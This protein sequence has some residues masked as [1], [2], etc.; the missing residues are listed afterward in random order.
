MPQD[1]SESDAFDI[2]QEEDISFQVN[3][4][5][6]IKSQSPNKMQEVIKDA[7][8]SKVIDASEF[9]VKFNL[10]VFV[11]VWIYHLLFFY[12]GFVALAFIIPI[13]SLALAINMGFWF[14][15]G[16]NS[17]WIQLSLCI[18]NSIV[19]TLFFMKWYMPKDG[20]F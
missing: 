9:V 1:F 18:S 13:D 19:L 12:F 20:P 11:K 14:S 17:I 3:E 7:V 8:L 4:T 6:K 15:R 2:P 10:K 5:R 16:N